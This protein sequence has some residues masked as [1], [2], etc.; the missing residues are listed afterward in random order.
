MQSGLEEK[1]NKNKNIKKNIALTPRK[2][3][4]ECKTPT[5]ILIELTAQEAQKKV[6]FSC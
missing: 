1:K 4:A 3:Q 2:D 6:L 5:S